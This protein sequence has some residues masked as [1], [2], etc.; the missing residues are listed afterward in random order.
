M[1]GIAFPNNQWPTLGVEL[2]LQLVDAET[3]A[4]TGA[5]DDVLAGVPADLAD[6]VKPEFLRSYVE[7]NTNTC[8]TVAEAAADLSRTVAAVDAAASR[9]GARLFWAG[10]HPFSR[11][12]DQQITPNERYHELA[13]L[14][15]ETVLRPVT[16]GMHV[17]VGV[18]S[19]DEAIGVI[20]RLMPHL[21]V[22][23]ALS[24]NSPLWH[25]RETGLHAYRIDMLE[26]MP[27]G[28][29]PPMLSGWDEYLALTG[30]LYDCGFIRSAKDLW[31]DVRPNSRY[32]TVEVRICD[33]PPDLP[34][35][36]GLTAL[37]QCLVH[38]LARHAAQAAPPE[39]HAE[40]LI[41]QNRWRAC[42]F[43]LD[44]ELVNIATGKA[45]PARECVRSL[46]ARLAPTAEALGCREELEHV[47]RMA[48][49]PTG[50]QRQLAIF[51]ETGDPA[52]VVRRL[53]DE[54]AAALHAPTA[55]PAGA[56]PL[57]PGA[58]HALGATLLATL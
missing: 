31:W 57:G 44:A 45:K 58:A 46:V 56:P 24:A 26:A 39:P 28:G 49:G 8:R 3:A 7:L 19:G 13:D 36:L 40:L 53:V 23:L 38:D 41:R 22:L 32:G 47:R 51:G 52:A 18:G 15:K 6:Q 50:A 29:L 17:H 54:A 30:R 25:G 10:T 37:I 9:C 34:G 5:I 43:G 2:E 11:W 21:P 48:D 16:F 35:V 55:P 14:L 20:N 33:M 4:L 1:S 42:R 12:R 27:T